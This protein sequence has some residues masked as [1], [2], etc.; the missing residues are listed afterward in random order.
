MVLR[1]TKCGQLSILFIISTIAVVTAG[2]V[3]ARTQKPKMIMVPAIAIADANISR[4]E[5]NVVT[6]DDSFA[7]V[8]ISQNT[9][10]SRNGAIVGFDKIKRGYKITCKG[11]WDTINSNVFNAAIFIGG[12]ATESDVM[13]RV[14][15]AC[16]KIA[17][18]G[19]SS[20]KHPSLP[21]ALKMDF[22]IAT[23]NGNLPEVKRLL[24]KD[25]TLLN[26]RDEATDFCGL[27]MAV[28]NG[29][30]EVVE[31]LIQNGANVNATDF[32]GYTA[33]HSAVKCGHKNIVRYL[34][35]HKANVNATSKDGQTPLDLLP[36]GSPSIRYLLNKYGATNGSR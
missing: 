31:F 24:K 35:D 25:S 13:D 23:T 21:N 8:H 20:S 14:A 18:K 3:Y 7:R 2:T 28:I 29:H 19:S 27:D 6:S 5:V 1:N 30:E 22:F 26:V 36:A 32:Q 16:Q 17:R 15:A 34:L 33:L 12:M 10:I 4:G 11:N 9:S